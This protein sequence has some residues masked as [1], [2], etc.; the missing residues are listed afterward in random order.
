MSELIVKRLAEPDETI[1]AKGVESRL[2][3][4]GGA[5]IA[6]DVHQPDWRWSTHVKPLVGTNSCEVRHVGYVVTGRMGVRLDSGEE[7]IIGPGEAFAIPPGHDGWVEGDEPLE[8]LDWT[9]GEEWLRPA[10]SVRVLASLV[11]TD[12]VDSTSQLRGMGDRRWREVLAGH[13]ERMRAI[14]EASGARFTESTGDGF[15]FAFDGAARAVNA[16]LRMVESAAAIEVPIR[17]AVN[18]G[19]IELVRGGVRGI[20]VHE[21]ARILSVAGKGEVLVSD[22]TRVLAGGGGLSFQNRGSHSLKGF[23]EPMSLFSAQRVG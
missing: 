3:D 12:I 20:A 23:D 7:V 22:V 1:R 8:T 17:A 9:G 18:A 16:A 15:L 11:M 6:Y 14:A 4:L 21:V 13:N 10:D 5:K 2:V 19:E